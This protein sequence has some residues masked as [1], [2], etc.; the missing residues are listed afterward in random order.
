MNKQLFL[1]FLLWNSKNLKTI[2]GIDF[3]Y[4]TVQPNDALSK[5]VKLK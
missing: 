4:S 2:T 5:T 1:L 3:K